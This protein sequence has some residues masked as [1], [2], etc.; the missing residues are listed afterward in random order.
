MPRVLGIETSCDETGVA[1][2]QDGMIL[3]QEL[4]SQ[5]ELHSLF[6]GVVPELASRRHLTVLPRL[7]DELLHRCG[8]GVDGVAVARG[9]GL[10]GALLVGLNYAKGLAFSLGVPLAGV[11]HLHAHLLAP[12]LEGDIPYPALGL[13]VSGGHSHIYRMDSPVEFELLGRTLDDA[14]GEAFDKAAKVLNLPYPGGAIIDSLAREA[15]PIP[16][17]FPIPYVDNDNLDFSFSGL[18]TAFANHAASNP[19]LRLRSL[20]GEGSVNS[21]KEAVHPEVPG[22]LASF[23]HSVSEACRIKLARALD[24]EAQ[25]RMPVAG[26]VLAGGVAA[27]SFLRDSMVSLARERDLPVILPSFA[28]CTDNAAMV[29][30]AGGVLLERNLGHDN[31]LDAVPRGRKVP[32]D[33]VSGLGFAGGERVDIG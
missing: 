13:L 7:C 25:R 21:T 30:L 19:H 8:G 17:L 10:L 26:L 23:S 3:A 28:L 16:E 32:D 11:N 15:E 9:P 18:K 5:A 31:S 27:N 29:A 12:G 1:L 6:G 22:V 33:A 20:P 14:A 2:V 24:R 4:A